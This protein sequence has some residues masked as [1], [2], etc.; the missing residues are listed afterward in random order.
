MKPI[1]KAILSRLDA[2]DRVAYSLVAGIFILRLFYINSMGLVADEAY[3]WD[4]SRHPAFGYFDHPPM[5]AWLIFLSTR[6]FGATVFGVKFVAVACSFLASLFTYRLA[7]K[8]VEKKSS[9]VILIL[10]SNFI[11]LFG[12][13]GLVATPDI[14]MVLFWSLSL[15]AAHAFI[16][17][18]GRFSWLLLGVFM[19][20]GLLSK[21][22]FV[23]FIISLL[24]FL[25]WSKEHRRLL[26]STRLWAA[27]LAALMLVLPNILWN[28]HHQWISV[29]Y[30]MGHGL[31][32]KSFPRIDFLGDFI[33]GQIGVLSVFPFVVL[34]LCVI[35]ETR[36]HLNNPKRMFVLAFFIVPLIFFTFSSLQK[37]VEPNWPCGAYV[38]GLLLVAF[39]WEET[40]I[41][42]RHFLRR[43]VFF[44]TIITVAATLV[45]LMHVQRPL[46]PLPP[47]KDPTIQA[48]GWRQWARRV[49]SVRKVIDPTITMPLFTK[50]YQD[51]AFLA[52]YLPDHP[53]TL[54]L[55]IGSRQSQ[56]S[57]SK[58]IAGLFGKR[59]LLVIPVRDSV[60]PSDIVRRLDG[61][62][63]RSIVYYSPVPAIHNPYAVFSA[64]LKKP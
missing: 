51:A 5:V 37:R 30:Q 7:K 55:S 35:N 34:V 64:T 32:G 57:L 38:S 63:N 62:G 36:F 31:G 41:F 17:G 44:S 27:M 18:K 22:L 50:L 47:D 10:L 59:V 52:F 58:D 28:S 21:Y 8:Y 13:G 60:L 56:Y 29:M 14:P 4:W 39:L 45:V 3:Y 54:A 46:L 48:R 11:I 40:I 20:C 2:S 43:F 33:G 23:L 1:F 53:H 9:F 61:I 19:G 25:L 49:D 12:V 15:L 42:N 6:L 24:V 16:F 26:Q